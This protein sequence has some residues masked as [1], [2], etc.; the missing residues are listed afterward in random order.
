MPRLYTSTVPLYIRD[1]SICG[2]WYPGGGEWRQGWPWSQWRR[3]AKEQLYTHHGHQWPEGSQ[4]FSAFPWIL[5]CVRR[6]WAHLF[7][8][9]PGAPVFCFF[10]CWLLPH[11]LSLL[12]C[13]PLNFHPFLSPP[14]F[15]LNVHPFSLYILFLGSLLHSQLFLP[16][17]LFL[18][19]LTSIKPG[20]PT[21]NSMF[22]YVDLYHST[23]FFKFIFS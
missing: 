19:T 6:F 11:L 20:V 4:H 15:I 13:Q 22:S 3:E 1:L 14:Q 10:H 23:S 21:P 7:P 18:L 9:F 2:L 5:S 8:W 12:G 17:Q 16:T